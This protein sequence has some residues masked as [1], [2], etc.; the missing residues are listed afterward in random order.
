MLGNLNSLELEARSSLI[1]LL[2]SESIADTDGFEVPNGMRREKA[3]GI[4]QLL[5][6]PKFEN[7][8]DR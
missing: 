2:F 1:L 5:E 3:K 6:V 8:S 4:S 7:T